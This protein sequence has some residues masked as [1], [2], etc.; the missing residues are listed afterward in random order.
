MLSS[1]L[2]FALFARDREAANA[3]RYI[4]GRGSREPRAFRRR[5]FDGRSGRPGVRACQGY[6]IDPKSPFLPPPSPEGTHNAAGAR[7]NGFTRVYINVIEIFVSRAVSR[8]DDIRVW[9]VRGA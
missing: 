6:P 8:L 1:Y 3:H 9:R 7:P 2:S 5:G 4:K